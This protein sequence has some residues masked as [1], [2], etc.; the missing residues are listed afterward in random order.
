[1]NAGRVLKTIV[2][3]WNFEFTFGLS[4]NLPMVYTAMLGE[5]IRIAGA[6]FLRDTSNMLRVLVVLKPN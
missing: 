1:M 4:V 2:V 5:K 3:C 6:E